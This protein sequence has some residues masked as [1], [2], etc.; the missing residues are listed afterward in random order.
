[1]LVTIPRSGNIRMV[2][3]II[4]IPF[5]LMSNLKDG[6][7]ITFQ[8]DC[9]VLD[10]ESFAEKYLEIFQDMLTIRQI[11]DQNMSA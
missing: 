7:P 10:A 1:M 9:R 6:R 5:L 8:L 11:I 3:T 2:L 4:V